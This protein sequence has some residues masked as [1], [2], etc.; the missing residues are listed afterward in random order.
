MTNF[1]RMAV[2]LSNFRIE[3]QKMRNAAVLDQDQYRRIKNRIYKIVEEMFFKNVNE[4]LKGT[5]KTDVHDL[6]GILVQ[7]R[8]VH[9]FNEIFLIK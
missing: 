7:A 6:I 3:W 9:S 8:K 4:C 2:A 1:L 5:G